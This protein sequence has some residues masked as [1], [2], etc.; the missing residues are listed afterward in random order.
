MK[1]S[2]S[3]PV[4]AIGGINENNVKEVITAG[5]DG[6]AV[7]SAVVSQEDVSA[8]AANLKRL[9]TEARGI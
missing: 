3:V 6:V 8:A 7:I 5:A 4:L 1:Q 2:V 9:I